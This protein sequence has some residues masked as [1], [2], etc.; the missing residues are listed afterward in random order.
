[1]L[2]LNQKHLPSAFEAKTQSINKIIIKIIQ[3]LLNDT[4]HGGDDGLPDIE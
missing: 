2:C 3:F 4:E 1:M